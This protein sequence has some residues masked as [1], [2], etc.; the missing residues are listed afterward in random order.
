MTTIGAKIDMTSQ[1][2]CPA[3]NNLIQYFYLCMGCAVCFQKKVPG[4]FKNICYIVFCS[5][6]FSAAVNLHWIT[7]S[8]GLITFDMVS[9]L[10]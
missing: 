3:G 10:M 1:S 6:A 5:A 8:K 4:V 2:F 7:I 9:L